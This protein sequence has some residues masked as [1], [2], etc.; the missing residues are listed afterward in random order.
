MQR[1]K[2]HFEQIQLEMVKK[3]AQEFPANNAIETESVSVETR[4]E[5][6][7][8][9]RDWREIAQLVQPEQNPERMI[10]LVKQLIETLDEEKRQEP[11]LPNIPQAERASL[12]V[13]NRVFSVWLFS[14]R[15]N[16]SCN[17]EGV[18]TRPTIF[19]PVWA[20]L[21][22]RKLCSGGVEREYSSDS[23]LGCPNGGP[24]ANIKPRQAGAHCSV[25]FG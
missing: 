6:P 2:T 9:E 11:Q 17:G 14:M 12:P 5:V 22:P 13:Q 10:G 8:G 19:S 21:S 20:E 15:L 4:D 1:S 3:I 23:R 24:R 16:L 25:L 18:P 7:S